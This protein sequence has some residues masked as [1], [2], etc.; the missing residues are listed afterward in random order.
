MHV[1]NPVMYS[2]DITQ[3]GTYNIC[4]SHL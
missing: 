2:P 3:C 1:Y 4:L